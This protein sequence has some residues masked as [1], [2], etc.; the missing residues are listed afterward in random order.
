MKNLALAALLLKAAFLSIGRNWGMALR[1]SF[2]PVVLPLGILIGWLY[3]AF[4]SGYARRYLPEHVGGNGDLPVFAIALAVLAAIG[5]LSAAVSWHRF[6]LRGDVPRLLNPLPGF[7][8]VLGYLGRSL[9]VGL[10]TIL[11]CVVLTLLVFPLT[12]RGPQGF[13]FRLGA[14]PEPLTWRNLLLSTI[15]WTVVTAL[16]LRWSLILPGG[17]VGRNLSLRE[18]RLAAGR[19]PLPVFV[20]LGLFLHLAP[21]GLDQLLSELPLGGYGA[22]LLLPFILLFWFMFGVALLTTLYAYCVEERPLVPQPAVV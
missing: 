19:V 22:L 5:T 11:I 13:N 15:V 16:L 4:T 18:A 12:D 3:W 14:L 8:P 1:A 9:L 21:I 7:R 17:A 6:D 20:L 2:V 10:I